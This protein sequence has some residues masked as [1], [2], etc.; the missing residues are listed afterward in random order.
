MPVGDLID[1]TN[2]SPQIAEYYSTFNL[3]IDA[4]TTRCQNYDM[5]ASVEIYE[6]FDIDTGTFGGKKFNL[7]KHSELF[8]LERVL[9]WQ[10]FVYEHFLH[11]DL[12]SD[13]WVKDLVLNALKPEVRDDVVQDLSELSDNQY[14]GASCIK[15]SFSK[16][17]SGSFEVTLL[18]QRCL[19]EFKITLYPGE[20]VSVAG[21]QIKALGKILQISNSLP[22]RVLAY[23]VRGMMLSSCAHFNAVCQQFLLNDEH[24]KPQKYGMDSNIPCH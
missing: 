4:L 5:M 19:T 14:G 8:S 21:Q 20:N 24:L 16:L 6:Y 2:F 7:F 9:D 13:T 22:A 23:V 1:T 11:E 15:I 12:Q 10:C 17:N 18:I 3:A